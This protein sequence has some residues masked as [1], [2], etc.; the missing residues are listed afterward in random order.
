MSGC[1][2]CSILRFENLHELSA[3]STAAVSGFCHGHIVSIEMDS[4][5]DSVPVFQYRCDLATLLRKGAAGD[6]ES[7]EL[8]PFMN[9]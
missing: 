8:L 1:S 4:V 2:R 9:T 5:K 3:D 7:G 6:R